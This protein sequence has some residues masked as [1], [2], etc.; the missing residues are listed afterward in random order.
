MILQENIK[1][2]SD[3]SDQRYVGK[4]ELQAQDVERGG[5]P[6]RCVGAV[7][8]SW[9]GPDQSRERGS[10]QAMSRV[11]SVAFRFSRAIRFNFLID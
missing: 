7:S 3:P 1:Q 9:G 2:A 11:Q 6:H 4:L 10:A 8:L 5:L